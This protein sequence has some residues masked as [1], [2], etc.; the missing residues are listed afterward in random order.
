MFPVYKK[1]DK[2]NVENYRGITSLCACS[3]VF[4]IIIH[5]MLFSACKNYISVDQH[6]FFPKRSVATNLVQFVSHCIRNMDAGAQTDVVYTDFK[7]AFDRVDHKIL[8]KRLETIGI[9]PDLTCWFETYLRDRQL[10]VKIGTE[11]S[12]TFTNTSGVPQGSNL[13]PLLFTL[14]I[15]DLAYLLPPGCRLFYA[16]DVKIYMLIKC[17][18]DCFALQS[19]VDKF[20]DWCSI[21]FLILSVHKCNVILPPEAKAY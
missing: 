10:C 15:N 6:G 21:N 1:G 20:T 18:D 12:D 8:L 14:F 7:S 19:L 17:H 5:E 16:D 2:R 3:K 11:C 9:S 4:E 13:G